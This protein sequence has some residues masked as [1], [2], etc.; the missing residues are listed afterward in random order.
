M[1]DKQ[2]KKIVYKETPDTVRVL[3]GYTNDKG[4]FLEIN[5]NYKSVLLKKNE[6]ISITTINKQARIDFNG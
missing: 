5:G 2:W 4:E 6:I 1:D 3:Q